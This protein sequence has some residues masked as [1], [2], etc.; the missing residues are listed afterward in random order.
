MAHPNEDRLRDLEE[1][2]RGHGDGLVARGLSG[3]PVV[4]GPALPKP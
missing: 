2:Y 1:I 3:L 4:P